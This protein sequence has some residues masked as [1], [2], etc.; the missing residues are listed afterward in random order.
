ME[1]ILT[2]IL[3]PLSIYLDVLGVT[4]T[5]GLEFARSLNG[6]DVVTTVQ[7]VS[8]ATCEQKCED[9]GRCKSAIYYR[10]AAYCVMTSTSPGVQTLEPSSKAVLPKDFHPNTEVSGLR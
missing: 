10:H 4:C 8:I 5:R 6:P 9:R 3:I 1:Q 7:G 2:A